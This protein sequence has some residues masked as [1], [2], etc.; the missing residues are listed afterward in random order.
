MNDERK[1]KAQ[2]INE[3]NQLRTRVKEWELE[4]NSFMNKGRETDWRLSFIA[5]HSDLV[6]IWSYNL[7]NGEFNVN[8]EWYEHL[9]YSA[10]QMEPNIETWERLIHPEDL[11][12]CR[13]SMKALLSGEIEFAS[14]QYRVLSSPDDWYQIH[15]K[16]IISE[17]NPEGEV[18]SAFGIFV[19]LSCWES[20]MWLYDEREALG[21]V[22]SE[23][24]TEMIASGTDVSHLK[25]LWSDDFP[26][27]VLGEELH[28]IYWVLEEEYHSRLKRRSFFVKDSS[29]RYVHVSPA[30][31]ELLG[32][33]A[34]QLL[35]RTDDQLFGVKEQRIIEKLIPPS[36]TGAVVGSV[37]L[38]KVNGKRRL[39]IDC[40]S[41]VDIPNR[42]DIYYV[43]GFSEPSAEITD[44]LRLVRVGETPYV[45]DA[46]LKTLGMALLAAQS[47]EVVL[48]TGETGTGKDYLAKYIH[49]NS[50][51]SEK[52]FLK[53]NCA[54]I[55]S[56][57]AESELFGHERG[58]FTSAFV[59]KK[60]LVELAEGGTLFLN[61]I[62]ELPLPM[63]AKLLTFLDSGEF[64]RV[65]SEKKRKADVRI[66]AATNRDLETQVFEKRFR[67][68]LFHRLDV[69]RIVLPTLSERKED[70]V[71]L[72]RQFLAELN[73]EYDEKRDIDP[74]TIP[75]LEEYDYQ[76]NVRQLKNLFRRARVFTKKQTIDAKSIF[77]NLSEQLKL[78]VRHPRPISKGDNSEDWE[79]RTDFPHERSYN[80]VVLDLRRSLVKEALRRADGHPI[81]AGRLLGMTKDAMRKQMETLGIKSVQ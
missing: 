47:D 74:K 12:P 78:K 33:T 21:K 11:L 42:D 68:D 70:I 13:D 61:E 63:Q 17:R 4:T 46:M 38:R 48:L 41:R 73:A 2:L 65:G 23:L 30:F 49:E 34:S 37:R 18:L 36:R 9:G 57:L 58:A 7:E 69:I 81:R 60:G 39:F 53:I 55:P 16:G 22:L 8:P 71:I 77:G 75:L 79:W 50:R 15:C 66:L 1:T 14:F 6:G 76:G 27:V 26:L 80:Q 72:A 62:G 43:R 54:A 45:S 29:M 56:E 5:K 25:E 59:E 35:G 32:M 44:D 52:K 24:F 10:E 40:L 28:S 64:I 67:E 31:A 20:A 51:R 19:D 3:L